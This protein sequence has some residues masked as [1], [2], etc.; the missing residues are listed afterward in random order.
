MLDIGTILVRHG[1]QK[2]VMQDSKMSRYSEVDPQKFS[3]EV[4]EALEIQKNK[5]GAK[6]GMINKDNG[7]PVETKFLY[8]CSI[9]YRKKTK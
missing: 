3:R 2:R 7:I 9:I 1:M 6:E 8:L 4:R 5:S